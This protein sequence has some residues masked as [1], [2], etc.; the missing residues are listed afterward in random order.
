MKIL[1][2][3]LRIASFFIIVGGFFYWQMHLMAYRDF[4][5]DN[6][7]MGKS[8]LV[9]GVI[10]TTLRESQVLYMD[11]GKFSEDPRNYS[12]INMDELKRIKYFLK[13]K[14]NPDILIV[15]A[16][17]HN[18]S[19]HPVFGVAKAI[20]SNRKV[21]FDKSNTLDRIITASYFICYADKPD[22]PL[23]SEL[24]IAK[25]NDKCPVGYLKR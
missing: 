15:S 20:T 17:P 14:S 13:V 23:P 16:L 6:T 5:Y 12:G 21:D 10:N 25:L 8:K 7:P 11:T 9:I 1:F 3:L 2:S 4:E 24:D 19:T 18:T 22:T